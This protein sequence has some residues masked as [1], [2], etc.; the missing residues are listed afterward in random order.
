MFRKRRV[1]PIVFS[2]MMVLMLVSAVTAETSQTER[3]YREAEVDAIYSAI[4]QAGAVYEYDQEII[5][6]QNQGMNLVCTLVVPRTPWKPPI[7]LTFNGFGED[8]HYVELP[9]TGGEYFYERLSRILAEQGIATLRVDYRGSGD[10][11]GTF[12]MTSFSSQISDALAAVEFVSTSKKLKKMVDVHRLGLVGFSQGGL[13][14]AITASK[15]KRVDSVALWSAVASPPITYE[16]LLKREGIQSGLDLPDG[17]VITIDVYIGDILYGSITLGK[18]FFT[19]LVSINPLP[20]MKDYKKPLLY[21]AGS[22]DQIVWPQPYMASMFLK[23]HEGFEKLVVLPTDHE[24]H[25]YLGVEEFD[26]TLYWTAAW[27]LYTLH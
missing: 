13:V 8:R 14:S 22:E 23:Y 11:D 12:D 7:A 2:I 25:T 3:V 5:S 16:Y 10:S 1:F 24:F 17:G 26:K 18:E 20:A 19:D 15:D 6:F 27:F 9:G 21:V 4:R